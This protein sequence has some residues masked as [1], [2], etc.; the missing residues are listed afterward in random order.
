MHTRFVMHRANNYV[1][2]RIY[3]I[4]SIFSVDSIFSIRRIYYLYLYGGVVCELFVRL[5]T[6]KNYKELKRLLWDKR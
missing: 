6:K 3:T 2:I 4:D 5:F 1:S